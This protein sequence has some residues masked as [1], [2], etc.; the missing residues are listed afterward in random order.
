MTMLMMMM[1]TLLLL[2]MTATC[3]LSQAHV[4]L[5]FEYQ[6]FLRKSRQTHHFTTVLR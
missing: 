1:M 2:S 3:P 5:V 4:D 6:A